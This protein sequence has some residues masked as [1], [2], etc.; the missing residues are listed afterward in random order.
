MLS[1]SAPLETCWSSAGD[2]I[3]VHGTERVERLQDHQVERALQ[4]VC[5]LRGALLD[6]LMEYRMCFIG[7]SNTGAET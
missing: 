5:L 1:C 4:H 6:M 2:G 3:A 7:L